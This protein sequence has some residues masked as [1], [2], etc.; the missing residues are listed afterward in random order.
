MFIERRQ[1]NAGYVITT[2]VDLEPCASNGSHFQLEG[3]LIMDS[4][5]RSNSLWVRNASRI[6]REGFRITFY[7]DIADADAHE[8]QKRLTE[9]ID[10]LRHFEAQ[11]HLYERLCEAREEPTL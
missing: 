7:G 6:A 11:T 1:N 10:Q 8:L 5:D 2:T 4:L 9:G 3:Q